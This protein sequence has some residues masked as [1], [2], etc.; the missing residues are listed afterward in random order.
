MFLVYVNELGPNYK[1]QNVYEFIF[2]DNL[3]GIWGEDWDKTP[4][5]AKQF[6]K[7]S[8]YVDHID[9]DTSNNHV[10]NLR[11]C[12]PLQNSSYRKNRGL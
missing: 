10:S 3:S 2:S 6:I 1:G 12:S 7:D 4:E 5:T 8:A 9:G 11:W